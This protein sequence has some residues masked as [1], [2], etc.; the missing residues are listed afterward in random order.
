MRPIPHNTQTLH[1]S[2]FRRDALH[3]RFL[4]HFRRSDYR[5]PALVKILPSF[6]K[7]DFF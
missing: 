5:L 4:G 2:S 6:G 7:S 3:L 1:A